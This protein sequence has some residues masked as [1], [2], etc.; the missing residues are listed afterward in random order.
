MRNNFSMLIKIVSSILKYSDGSY[1]LPFVLN[2]FFEG[3]A[4]YEVVFDCNPRKRVL[5]L[6]QYGRLLG[7]YN[8]YSSKYDEI[9]ISY[10]DLT[11]WLPYLK[12]DDYIKEI[13]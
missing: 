9:I 11:H 5:M 7:S 2:I 1:D 6:D 13:N 4:I 10:S 3:I 8:G 12:E